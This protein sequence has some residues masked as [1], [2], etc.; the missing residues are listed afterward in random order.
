MIV[1]LEG[2]DFFAHHGVYAEERKIGNRYSVDVEVEL[3]DQDWS[4]DDLSATVNYESIYKIVEGVMGHPTRLLE[5]IADELTTT[6]LDQFSKIETTTVTVS[7]HNPPIKGVC[8][9]ASVTFSKK[10]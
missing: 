7:K 6:L 4:T 8:D 5:T 1:K 10:R 9:K 3:T 2:L